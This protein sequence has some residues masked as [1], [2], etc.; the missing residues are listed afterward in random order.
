MFANGVAVG[1]VLGLMVMGLGLALPWRR[2][3][4]GYGSLYREPLPLSDEMKLRL[5]MSMCAYDDGTD[6]AETRRHAGVSATSQAFCSRCRMP[7][8]E[9][10]HLE[11]EPC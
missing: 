1:F 7:Y 2:A 5:G 9:S 11:G 3:R 4:V 6:G 10:T 8:H